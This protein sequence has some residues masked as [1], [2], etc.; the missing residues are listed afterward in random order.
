MAA[1]LILITLAIVVAVLTR[2]FRATGD[3]GADEIGRALE[4][5]K[6]AKYRELREL[7]LDWRTGKLSDADYQQT[8][9]RLR[10]EAAALLPRT[11]PDR[12]DPASP[13]GT[14]A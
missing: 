5:A 12:D 2:A 4:E 1:L 10:E 3:E 11:P 9:G 14:A 6:L 8:R 13:N 7:E